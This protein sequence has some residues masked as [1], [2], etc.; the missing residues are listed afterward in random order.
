[1]DI[2]PTFF[3]GVRLVIGLVLMIASFIAR[4]IVWG[5]RLGGKPE[6]ITW[7][8]RMFMLLGGSV[9]VYES[10]LAIL[11]QLQVAVNPSWHDIGLP[12][13]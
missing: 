10:G 1:M 7:F 3:D 2:V 13:A 11:Q 9:L 12:L 4:T 8:G 6:K 5:R